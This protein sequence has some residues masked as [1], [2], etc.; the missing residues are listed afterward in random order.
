MPSDLVERNPLQGF[1]ATCL[2]QAEPL[3]FSAVEPRDPN[4]KSRSANGH[5]VIRFRLY[6]EVHISICKTYFNSKSKLY[7]K[8]K[9]LLA[10]EF[11]QDRLR[12]KLVEVELSRV[13]LSI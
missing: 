1:D 3:L 8:K 6:R 4:Q 7:L 11:S 12:Q 9:T 10:F 13:R 5:P 2:V